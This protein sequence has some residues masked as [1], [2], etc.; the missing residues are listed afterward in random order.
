[1]KNLAIV[2]AFVF[3]SSINSNSHSATSILPPILIEKNNFP[4]RWEKLGTRKVNY[5]LDRDEI[6]VTAREGRFQKLR[7]QVTKGGIN[8]HRVVVHFANGTTQTIKV[9]QS[10]PPGSQ[11]RPLDLDGNKRVIQK[12]VFYYDTKNFSG[13]KATVTLWGRH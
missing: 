9:N 13:R 6:Y 2:L 10:I 7:L 1:M 4:P 8:L 12:V 3:S 11:S 5:R